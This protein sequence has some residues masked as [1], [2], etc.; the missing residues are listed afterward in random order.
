M[1]LA[2]GQARTTTY[3]RGVRYTVRPASRGGRSAI[4]E[5]GARRGWEGERSGRT[6]DGVISATKVHRALLQQI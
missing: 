3:V 6:S 1:A 5:E 4:S 2:R